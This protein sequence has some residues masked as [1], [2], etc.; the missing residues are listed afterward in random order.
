MAK[1]T[2]YS[3]NKLRGP[4]ISLDYGKYNKCDLEGFCNIKSARLKGHTFVKLFEGCKYNGRFI[5]LSN[6][7]SSTITLPNVKV[8]FCVNSIIID[9]KCQYDI[10]LDNVQKKTNNYNKLYDCDG[11]PKNINPYD[12]KSCCEDKCFTNDCDKQTNKSFNCEYEIIRSSFLRNGVE[13]NYTYYHIFNENNT[14]NVNP[15]IFILPDLGFS[16]YLYECLQKR[17]LELKLS[18][19]VVD[20]RGVGLSA[21]VTTDV[22]WFTLVEDFRYVTYQLNAYVRR[23]ILLGYGFGGVIAQLW[24]LLY[25]YELRNLILVNSAPMNYY[26]TSYN[27][28]APTIKQFINNRISYETFVN[29]LVNAYVNTGMDADIFKVKIE[30]SMLNADQQA[31]KQYITFNDDIIMNLNLKNINIPTLIINAKNDQFINIDAGNDLNK[32]ISESML[33]LLN[34]DHVP[35]F[36]DLEYF[37]RNMYNYLNPNGMEDIT[38]LFFDVPELLY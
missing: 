16:K 22:N 4:N 2:L 30:E 11:C 21:N 14:N 19:I 3:E 37:L 12:K 32:M 10:G 35:N 7:G 9:Y 33:I 23:P 1:V 28:Y 38:N 29:V 27:Q 18:S 8:C 20:Q 24:S 34:I 13:I 25:N 36:S 17:L 31:I 5:T 15:T 6:K 26:F